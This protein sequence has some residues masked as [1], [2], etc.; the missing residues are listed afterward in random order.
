[1]DE[2]A[3]GLGLESE[4]L[5]LYCLILMKLQF[6]ARPSFTSLRLLSFAVS[7]LNPRRRREAPERNW[8]LPSFLPAPCPR[9]LTLTLTFTLTLTLTHPFG[10]GTAPLLP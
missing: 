6:V 4:V 8:T 7:S 2:R 9:T 1:M 5:Q 3:V 10:G